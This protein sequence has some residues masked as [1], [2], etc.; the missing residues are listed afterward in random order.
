MRTPS[1]RTPE[2]AP[3]KGKPTDFYLWSQIK[4]KQTIPSRQHL[5]FH[6]ITISL[7]TTVSSFATTGEYTLA[8]TAQTFLFQ[9]IPFHP[10]TL[11]GCPTPRRQASASP[12]HSSGQ[13][14]QAKA[15]A[16]SLLAPCVRGPCWH[17]PGA[18]RLTALRA[19]ARG[20]WFGMLSCEG[21]GGLQTVKPPPKGRGAPDG[22]RWCCDAAV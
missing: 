21:A 14:V 16:A 13:R 11:A 15:S 4:Q 18:G 20:G 22:C 1:N 7:I 12:K 8:G 9:K 17:L 3:G 19:P 2:V 10:K 6:L 5:W